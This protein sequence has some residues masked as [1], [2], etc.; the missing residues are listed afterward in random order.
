MHPYNKFK[1]CSFTR[2]GDM[3]EGVTNLIRVTWLSLGPFCEILFLRFGEIVHM[4]LLAKFQ[5]CSCTRFGDMFKGVPNFI[6]VTWLRPRPFSTFLFLH[7]WEIVHVQPYAIF[8]VRIA[9]RV[10]EICLRE[11]QIYKDH[12]TYA[13]RDTLLAKICSRAAL[14]WRYWAV[15]QIS[16]ACYCLARSTCIMCLPYMHCSA[17]HV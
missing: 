16:S 6:R 12:V 10:L 1:V 11:C 4:H 9:L 8:E 14:V 2:F 15:C 17:A 13:T 7:F 5:V 3:L